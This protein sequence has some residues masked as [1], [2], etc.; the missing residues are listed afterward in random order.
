MSLH[1]WFGLTNVVVAA[2]SFVAW[3]RACVRGTVVSVLFCLCYAFVLSVLVCF[4][5]FLFCRF[6]RSGIYVMC[7]VQ[8][9]F[10][11]DVLGFEF[12]EKKQIL[13]TW[14]RDRD[15]SSFL[16]SDETLLDGM[17]VCL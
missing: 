17:W 6:L 10:I 3:F 14:I 8:V 2:L 13:C 16:D 7:V 15:D 12:V 5:L 1:V 9:V 4:W 11:V